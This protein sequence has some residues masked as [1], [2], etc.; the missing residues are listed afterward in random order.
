MTL[1]LIRQ[2]PF[3]SGQMG[4]DGSDV[5]LGMRWGTTA[6]T[7]WVDPDHADAGDAHDGTD[8]EHPLETIQQAI[9]TLTAHQNGNQ[10]IPLL[11][12]LRSDDV[13]PCLCCMHDW[14]HK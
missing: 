10:R 14:Q 7:M 11:P 13:L 5:P 1:P 6:I 12:N 8:P 4:V 3:Y 9:T 2:T